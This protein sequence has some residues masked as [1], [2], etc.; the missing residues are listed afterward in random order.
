MSAHS[1][2]PW[3]ATQEFANRWRVDQVPA[4]YYPVAAVYGHGDLSV[5]EA[6]ARLLSAAPDLLAA[7]KGRVKNEEQRI[8]EDWLHD[9]TPSGDVEQ[10]QDQWERSSEYLDF[11]DAWAVEISAIFKAERKI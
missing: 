4:T 3:I 5:I 9:K 10:V 6:N 8:F 2:G 1:K 11:H 7:L